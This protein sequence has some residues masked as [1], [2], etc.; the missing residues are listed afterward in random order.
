MK[1]RKR[2]LC[3]LEP[4]YWIWPFWI[5]KEKMTVDQYAIHNRGWPF[6][7]SCPFPQP[8]SKIQFWWD[9]CVPEFEGF[10]KKRSTL[11]RTLKCLR[12]K[13][14]SAYR[15]GFVS[16]RMKTLAQWRSLS[17]GIVGVIQCCF[18]AWLIFL[19]LCWKWTD[20]MEI[21]FPGEKLNPGDTLTSPPYHVGANQQLAPGASP[22]AFAT[23]RQPPPLL[24][25]VR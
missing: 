11:D 4:N 8:L 10:W 22:Q 6:G 25:F 17:C 19:Y 18:R 14:W 15:F 7:L 3:D 2:K 21:F 12:Y 16:C 13:W 5:R 24:H 1:V 20:F 23:S 9:S